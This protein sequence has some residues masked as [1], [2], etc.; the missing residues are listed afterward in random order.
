MKHPDELCAGLNKIYEY[1]HLSMKHYL[2]NR[3]YGNF[4]FH[5]NNDF[6]KKIISTTVFFSTM[7]LKEAAN[8][9]DRSE[10]YYEHPNFIYITVL[11]EILLMLSV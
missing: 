5:N 9:T 11:S 1:L 7:I 8:M 3:L 2:L 10:Q 4:K 6:F